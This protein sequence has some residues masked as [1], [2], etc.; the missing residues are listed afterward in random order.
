LIGT[1]DDGA[2]VHAPDRVVRLQDYIPQKWRVLF[3]GLNPGM[4]IGGTKRI[5]DSFGDMARYF[6]HRDRG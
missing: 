4:R 2:I 5:V 1:F 3:V 6:A